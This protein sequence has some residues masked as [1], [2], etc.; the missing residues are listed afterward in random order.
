M[1][2]FLELH[3]CGHTPL[4]SSQTGNRQYCILSSECTRAFLLYEVVSSSLSWA[5]ITKFDKSTLLDAAPLL[6]YWPILTKIGTSALL[7]AVQIMKPPEGK[8]AFELC[9]KAIS[10]CDVIF[11]FLSWAVTTKH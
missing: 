7:D 6:S 5:I 11:P 9:T 1:P 10:L 3:Q 8:S 2:C 4:P